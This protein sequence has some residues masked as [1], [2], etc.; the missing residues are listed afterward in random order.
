MTAPRISTTNHSTVIPRLRALRAV[1]AERGIDAVLIPSSDPH[2]SEYLPERWQG[3][4]WFSGFTGSA[5]TMIVTR[6]VAG[7]WTDARY[8]EQAEAELAG[9]TV[10]LMRVAPGAGANYIEWLVE[11]LQ[12]GQ[13]VAVDGAVLGLA[14]GRQLQQSLAARGIVLDA[15]SDPLHDVWTDRPG[16]PTVPIYEHGAPYAANSRS[17]KLAAVRAAMARVGAG[18]HVVSTL[19]DIAYLLNLRGADV[20]FNPVFLA[21]VLIDAEHGVLFI[22]EGRVDPALRALLCEDGVDLA[23]YEAFTR[24]LADL[25]ADTVL[26]LDPRR[27]TFGTCRSIPQGVKVIDAVNP[28]TLAKAVKEDV[29]IDHVRSAMVEDGAALCEFFAWL[30]PLLAPREARMVAGTAPTE[31]DIDARLTAVRAQRPGFVGRS[32]ATIAGFN[33][34][35]A[36]VHYRATETS[37]RRI[38][39]DGLLLI[40]SGAQYVGGTTDITRMVAVGTTSTAQRRDCTLV[41]KGLIALSSARFP[42]GVRAPMLDSLARSPIWAEGIDYG[43][44]T[45]H[46][47]G[48]FLNVHEGPQSISS[49]AMPE[50]HTAMLPG[51]ITSIEPGIYRP[52]HWGVRIENL[53]LNRFAEHTAFGD[54]LCFETLT[55][56]P[57][58]TRCLDLS[59]LSA[60]E[61]T[62]L[63]AYHATVRARLFSL[64]DGPALAWLLERTTPV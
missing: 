47:V 50:P 62:W 52:G 9:S 39:G 41:L 44:G 12:P 23:P 18:C 8:W 6:D 35:G 60:E 10:Q 58:D 46:G 31:L 2:L 55:L 59:M 26:L 49:T 32:F 48:Y 56:C 64:L 42:L 22:G 20:E 63:N 37:H 17:V 29:E 38:T 40:D 16:L 61:R 36:I 15:V 3:R 53:V 54:F 1:M 7:V 19:D 5:G 33:A 45:G 21:H 28:T 34:N 30:E 43:H 51:M 4:Q 27:V 11:T 13:K 25:P 14:V 57:I 24:A